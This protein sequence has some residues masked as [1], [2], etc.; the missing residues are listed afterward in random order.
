MFDKVIYAI[1]I[2]VMVSCTEPIKMSNYQVTDICRMSPR[3][4]EKLDKF[5][6]KGILGNNLKIGFINAFVITDEKYPSQEIFV[7]SEMK[8]SPG[9]VGDRICINIKLYKEISFRGKTILLFK[10]E[11]DKNQ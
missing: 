3:K 2:L 11:S 8:T 7:F 1:L 5:R 9:L 10:E 6:I 4:I